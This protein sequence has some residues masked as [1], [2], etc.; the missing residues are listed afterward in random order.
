MMVLGLIRKETATMSDG[1]KGSRVC[2][3]WNSSGSFAALRMTAELATTTITTTTT[4]T[5]MATANADA[6]TSANGGFFAGLRMTEICGE[7]IQRGW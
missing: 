5:T 3:E 2:G 7:G 6:N 1:L 4:A